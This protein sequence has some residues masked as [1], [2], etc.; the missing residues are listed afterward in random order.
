[1]SSEALSPAMH[2]KER[3]VDKDSLYLD[4]GK[5]EINGKIDTITGGSTN[6]SIAHRGSDFGGSECSSNTSPSA[7]SRSPLEGPRK[8]SGRSFKVNNA[9]IGG[10]SAFLKAAIHRT[11]QK[12]DEDSKNDTSPTVIRSDKKRNTDFVQTHN[13]DKVRTPSHSPTY[14]KASDSPTEKAD[15]AFQIKVEQVPSSSIP[16]FGQKPSD[17]PVRRFQPFAQKE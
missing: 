17:G 13:P 3:Y 7:F 5:P 2:L 8:A 11:I 16:G 9:S 12:N 6:N 1:M 15:S 4:V 10:N 14:Y